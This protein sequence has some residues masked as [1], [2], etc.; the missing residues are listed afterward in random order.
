M[1]NKDKTT[2]QLL[3]EIA[4][5]H[6][7]RT[8]LERSEVERSRAEAALRES[9][10]KYRN[11]VESTLDLIFMVNKEGTYTYVN[12][13]FEKVTG[14][15][16][17]DLIGQPF[18]YIVAPEY[19]ESTIDRFKK[20]IRGEDTPPY[21]AELVHKNGE[22][23]PVE[24][25]VTT[26]Y[27]TMGRATGRFGIGRDITERRKA[28]NA[29]RQIA[30]DL[31]KAQD[32]AHIGSWRY[33]RITKLSVWSEEMFRIFGLKPNQGTPFHADHKKFIHP[34]DWQKVET[35]VRA[36][37]GGEPYGL[38]LRI[39]RPDGSMRYVFTTGETEVGQ[40]GKVEGLFGTTQDITE[41]KLVEKTL[42]K[43]SDQ[44]RFL[45]AKLSEAEES[46]R[47]RIARD[48][49]DQVGQNLTVVG[50]NLNVLRSMLPEE[51]I[52]MVQTRLLEDSLTLVEQ[53]TEY[54]RSLMA[55]LRPPDMD[56]YGLVASIRWYSERFSMRTGVEVIMEG[57]EI[58]PRPTTHI[59]NNLFRIV[60]EVLTNISKHARAR[61]ARIKI[62]T[63]EGKLN[64]S[65]VDDGVGF[66]PAE[67]HKAGEHH[68]WG[69]LTMAER[70][71]VIGGRF[72]LE[73]KT[74]QGTQVTVEVPL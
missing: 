70:A 51:S 60:Q 72:S 58:N 25:L 13:R 21:E 73:S 23:I 48:L 50:I 46:E 22:R 7:T 52:K 53:T 2:P 57:R 10:E 20:G 56:D 37:L 55:D 34:D 69:L 16:V 59:E 39:L 28:D 4:L 6:Q 9:E 26:Q 18:T 63:A 15:S 42:K 33:N 1:R 45:S 38:E 27:D 40:D 44:L 74:G 64:L 68:G 71:E 49:H 14:Y 65:I 54:T 24:F 5:L 61:H 3:D 29:L 67:V 62:D 66:D 19:K 30:A 17:R 36:A 47:R 32:L 35:S 41:R 8:Q 31:A 12:P 11:L 43:Q